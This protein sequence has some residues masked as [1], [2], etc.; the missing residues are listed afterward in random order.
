[1]TGLI[2][3]AVKVTCFSFSLKSLQLT[4][5]DLTNQQFRLCRGGWG[6]EG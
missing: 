6:E 4:I 2:L 1:M 5:T 3:A